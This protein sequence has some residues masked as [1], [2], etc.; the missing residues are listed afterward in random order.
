L[1]INTDQLRY[2]SLGFTGNRIVK[3]PNLDALAAAGII[4]TQAYTPLLP[5]DDP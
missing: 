3:T 5:A 2:D 4:F 1:F